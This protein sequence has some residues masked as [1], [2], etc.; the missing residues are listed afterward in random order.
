MAVNKVVFGAVSI[1]DITD[2]T[3]TPEKLT[4]GETAYDKS[5]EK[6]EGTNPYEKTATDS[7]VDLQAQKIAQL[8]TILNGK[9]L[10]GGSGGTLEACTV[11][12]SYEFPMPTGYE[13][14]YMDS[15]GQNRTITDDSEL[16]IEVMKNSWIVLYG[17]G[18]LAELS[19]D[20]TDVG[21]S[22]GVPLRIYSVSGDCSIVYR[23]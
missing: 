7:E 23:G 3:V 12:L 15:T 18:A 21:F 2:S 22:I 8:S 13:I 11:S 19:G 4:K 20:I 10:G 6:I 17:W 16:S 14:Y 5:G 9:A 1:M